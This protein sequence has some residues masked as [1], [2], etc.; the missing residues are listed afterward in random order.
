[1]MGKF[2]NQTFII[3][4]LI[5]FYLSFTYHLQFILMAWFLN[6]HHVEQ[7]IHDRSYNASDVSVL[8]QIPQYCLVGM[9]EVF[10]GVAGND[11]GLGDWRQYL[12][13]WTN[14]IISSFLHTS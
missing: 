6:R 13:I 3:L 11:R 2:T 10:A 14:F 4:F 7:V 5:K 9:A 12:S 8:W 1:M